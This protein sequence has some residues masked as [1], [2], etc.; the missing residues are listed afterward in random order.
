MNFQVLEEV[1][2]KYGNKVN[3][4]WAYSVEAHPEELRFPDGIETRDLG[5][6]HRYFN[7]TA[8]EQRARSLEGNPTMKS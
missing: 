7:T 5:W 4:L 3:F 1:Y 8:M 2:Q 6:D